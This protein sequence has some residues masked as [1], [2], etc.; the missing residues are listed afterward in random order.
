M[1]MKKIYLLTCVNE[2]CEVVSVSLHPTIAKAKKQMKAEYKAEVE[3]LIAS[4]FIE[5]GEDPEDYGC[6]LSDKSAVIG[7]GCFDSTYKWAIHEEE[8]PNA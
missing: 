7:W 2:E 8:L 1:L 3:D 6:D 4:G 5:E